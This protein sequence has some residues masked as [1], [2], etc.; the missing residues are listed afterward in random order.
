MERMRSV[1]SHGVAFLPLKWGAGPM[2]VLLWLMGSFYIHGVATAYGFDSPSSD[3][4]GMHL[5]RKEIVCWVWWSTL[6]EVVMS[7]LSDHAGPGSALSVSKFAFHTLLLL[8]A[9]YLGSFW[10][11]D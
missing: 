5:P 8:L 9:K 10:T 1:V 11:E 3:W 6:A 7:E 4:S 2:A